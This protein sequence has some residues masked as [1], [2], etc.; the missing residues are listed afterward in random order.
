MDIGRFLAE[1]L[2]GG[3]KGFA[4]RLGRVR[5]IG[6]AAR[7]LLDRQADDERK[8]QAGQ[9]DGNEGN[10]PALKA[11]PVDET[12]GPVPAPAFEQGMN[13]LA[14]NVIIDGAGSEAG[15]HAAERNTQ[16][17]DGRGGGPATGLEI[18]RDNRL[19]GRRAPGLTNS[20]QKAE[21]EHGRETDSKS[22]Q[23]GH[24]APHGQRRH[25]NHHA[26]GLFRETGNRNAERRVE[27]GKGEPAQQAHLPVFEA[28]TVADRIGQ[29]AE[30]RPVDEIEDVDDQERG[31]DIGPISLGAVTSFK[32]G[33]FVQCCRRG[34]GRICHTVGVFPSLCFRCPYRRSVHPDCTCPS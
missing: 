22:A 25:D 3:A 9:A 24:Q 19:G 20:D 15:A 28:Q 17:V 33:L 26:A 10:P 2:Q 13:I 5:R 27:S 7:W 32:T 34:G 1:L 12:G 6:V 30:D 8:K 31:Q 18:V 4:F 14:G 21:G 23:D 29:D 16:R 11:F